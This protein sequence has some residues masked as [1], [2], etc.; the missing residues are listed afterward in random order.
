M[1]HADIWGQKLLDSTLFPGPCPSLVMVP[2]K[3]ISARLA[4]AKPVSW[5][6]RSDLPQHPWGREWGSLCC[7]ALLA[8]GVHFYALSAESDPDA[9]QCAAHAMP[10]MDELWAC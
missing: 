4:A 8:M 5:R 9:V 3:D 10:N 6:G 7:V 2:P 1:I